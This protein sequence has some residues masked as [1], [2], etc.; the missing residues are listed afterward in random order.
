MIVKDLNTLCRPLDEQYVNQFCYSDLAV[1][2]FRNRWSV[3]L[4]YASSCYPSFW[5]Y[6]I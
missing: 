2:Y 3:S 4:E 1:D 5:K 6:G